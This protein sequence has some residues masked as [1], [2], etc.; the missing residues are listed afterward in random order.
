MSACRLGKFGARK[1]LYKPYWGLTFTA[2]EANVVINMAKVGS[3]LNVV[4]L[5]T[6]FD[7]A[8]WTS[9]D[10]DNQTT[11]ITLANVG[12]KVYFRSGTGGNETISS[13]VRNYRRFSSTGLF[14]ASGNIMSII[15]GTD[16]SL[17]EVADLAFLRLFSGNPITSAPDLPAL[18]LCGR[19]YGYMFY[20][21]THLI[22]APFLPS[23]DVATNQYDR[24]FYGCSSLTEISVSFTSWPTTSVSW[25][26]GVAATGTFYCPAAL[27]TNETITR[28]VDACPEGWTV[29]NI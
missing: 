13:N 18:T 9:F 28:G 24:M 29:V 22:K 2:E 27:G 5:E 4:T 21:C 12:D 26:N 20:N 25:V 7:G 23:T 3:P 6:S 19:C 14:S 10:A 8:T 15:D 16:P 1:L 17:T 11:P